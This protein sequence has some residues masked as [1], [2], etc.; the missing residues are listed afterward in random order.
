MAIYCDESGGVGAGVMTL[1]SVNLPGD[2][3][4]VVLER[5]RSVIGLRGELKGSRITLPER[6]FLIELLFAHGAHVVVA[7]AVIRTLVEGK[8]GTKPPQDIRLYARLLET[9]VDDWLPQTG[10]CVDLVIDDGRY[11]PVLN[12]MLRQDVQRSLGQWGKAELADSRRS[13][14]VQIADVLANSFYQIGMRTERAH[15]VEA[16]M[17]PFRDDGRLKLIEITSVD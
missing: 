5:Y 11:D 1:A 6:A 3:A 13:P 10:G 9:V 4:D 17:Q 12:G 7:G 15:R 14:G 16:L 8:P 2:A